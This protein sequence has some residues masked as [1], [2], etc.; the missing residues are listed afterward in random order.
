MAAMSN[1]V[2]RWHS[3]HLAN[4]HPSP[5][6]PF[7][8]TSSYLPH[9]IHTANPDQLSLLFASRCLGCHESWRSGQSERGCVSEECVHAC[10]ND[11]CPYNE[12]LDAYQRHGEVCVYHESLVE[13]AVKQVED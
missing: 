12:Y 5:I 11:S 2:P 7:R 1:G 9:T 4:T 8:P 13:H 6:A 3:G 10:H